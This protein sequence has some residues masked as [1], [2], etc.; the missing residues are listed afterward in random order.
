MLKI[1]K[2]YR[3]VT[4]EHICPFGIKAKDLLERQGYDVDD[5]YLTTRQEVEQFKEK[6][7]VLT[8]PQV[9]LAGERI[10]GYDELL[11]FFSL[12]SLKQ[13]EKSYQ[14]II[15]IF[16]ISLLI[17]LS[18]CYALYGMII[19]P[20]TFTL[21]TGTALS[22][23]ALMKLKDLY[24][25]SNQFITYDLLAQHYVGYAYIYPFM[26]AFAGL[27]IIGGVSMSIVAPMMLFMGFIGAYSVYNAV[28]L[29]QKDLK[30]ACVG[31]NSNVPLGMVSLIE[32]LIMIFMGLRFYTQ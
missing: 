6:H 26:E 1:A 28:Y 17:A 5:N 25:F 3:M 22:I 9:F 21:F 30:C 10:G 18:I 32:N 19:I 24:S 14:P 29:E 11:N 7:H 15:A 20:E 12:P 23:L 4:N 8:T 31:G 27:S 16:S 2:L 13:G